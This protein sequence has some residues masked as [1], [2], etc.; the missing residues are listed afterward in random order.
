MAHT[1][2]TLE[3]W[4]DE[5]AVYLVQLL[6]QHPEK[7][8]VEFYVPEELTEEYSEGEIA[9]GCGYFSECLF[10]CGVEGE[11]EVS[12]FP[13]TKRVRVELVDSYMSE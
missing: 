13:I 1:Y 3:E 5:K 7:T 8:R 10:D 2:V 6:G 9:T 4:I 11:R 12:Y